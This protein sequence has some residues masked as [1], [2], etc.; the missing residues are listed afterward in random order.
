MQRHNHHT[1]LRGAFFVELIELVLERLLVGGRIVALEREGAWSLDLDIDSQC[2]LERIEQPLSL[3]R[4][5]DRT[6]GQLEKI[7]DG[8]SATRY[9]IQGRNER[10]LVSCACRYGYYVARP[11]DCVPISG[12][13][14]VAAWCSAIDLCISTVLAALTAGY[15]LGGFIADRK[16]KQPQSLRTVID[17]EYT[18]CTVRT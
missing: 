16:W 6:L 2:G 11:R 8:T 17:A 7:G 3:Q 13:R 15:F 4:L 18:E 5:V 12:R 1:T 10:F 9:P 14:A